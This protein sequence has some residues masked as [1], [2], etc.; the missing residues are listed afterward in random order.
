MRR[1]IKKTIS[2][3]L[4]CV[5]TAGLFMVNST[6][7]LNT[8]AADED[9][10]IN[11]KYAQILN[12]SEYDEYKAYTDNL[13]LING[14]ST[15]S[16]MSNSNIGGSNGWN[17]TAELKQDA[18]LTFIDKNGNKN[19]INNK[20]DDG[21]TK[22]DRVY[23][24]I[25]KLFYKYTIVGKADKITLI[26]SK[27]EYVGLDNNEWYDGLDVYMIGG[28][29]KRGNY[30]KKGSICYGIYYKQPDNSY[31][32]KVIKEDGNLFFEDSNVKS[33]EEIRDNN[34][35]MYGITYL[36]IRHTDDTFTL[37][38]AE[39]NIWYRNQKGLTGYDK[40]EASGT[41]KT[42]IVLNFGDRSEYIDYKSGVK[43]EVKGILQC[44]NHGGTVAF[45]SIYDGGLTCYDSDMNEWFSVKGDYTNANL[46]YDEEYKFAG[47]KLTY[48]DGTN[49]ICDKTGRLF[50]PKGMKLVRD[51]NADN[52]GYNKFVDDADNEK[53]Y[54]VT[55][56]GNNIVDLEETRRIADDSISALKNCEISKV[57]EYYY[58]SGIVYNYT[59]TN[60]A[61]KGNVNRAVIVT[62]ESNYTKAE[63]F[64]AKEGIVISEGMYYEPY[65]YYFDNG[66]LYIYSSSRGSLTLENGSDISIGY[67]LLYAYYLKEDNMITIGLDRDLYSSRLSGAKYSNDGKEYIITKEGVIEYRKSTDVINKTDRYYIDDT[68]YFYEI[69]YNKNNKPIY[70]LFNPERNII[71]IGLEKLYNDNL[72]TAINLTNINGYLFLTYSRNNISYKEIYTYS[73]VLVSDDNKTMIDKYQAYN[74]Y[75][76][77]GMFVYLHDSKVIFLRNILNKEISQILKSSDI[78]LKSVEGM[79]TQIMT[80]IA[81]NTTACDVQNMFNADNIILVDREGKELSENSKVGTGCIVNL[82]R[83]GK[84]VD[85]ATVVVKGD[86]DGSGTIDVLDMEAVQKSILGIGEGLTGAYNEAA[87]L[88]ESDKISV[89]DME[90][91][92]KDILG[93]QKIN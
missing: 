84:V 25:T 8:Q 53:Q 11:L 31:N 41:G 38:D 19:V 85:T 92:Q 7:I 71:D 28:T 62:K 24:T 87:K 81:D 49:N 13:L 55:K 59:L 66:Y 82:L 20:N 30:T 88:S 74:Y 18:T 35:Q 54:L 86:T 12:D 64:P 32:Y 33:V 26:N 42:W 72:V 43:K 45:W 9:A 57:V 40:P 3:I 6:A 44:E 67:K 90:A 21:T 48:K 16:Q 68:G 69:T 78:G 93:L 80:G 17:Q 65:T 56:D 23:S 2:A 77:N 4:A 91:I 14:L 63:V 83:D 52:A 70:K 29:V 27:G 79:K 75:Y 22:Y 58:R 50:L 1:V 37:I 47:L 36:L 60:L 5:M 51:Y 73:G 76:F 34:Q 15:Y 61:G 46:Y 89:L 10:Y 39:G